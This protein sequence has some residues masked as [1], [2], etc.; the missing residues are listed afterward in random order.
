MDPSQTPLM[1]PLKRLSPYGIAVVLTLAAFLVR[2]AILPHIGSS[3]PFITFFLA[4]LL[5]TLNG[6]ARPGLFCVALS[7]VASLYFLPPVGSLVIYNTSDWMS[8]AL[9]IVVATSLVLLTESLRTARDRA[10]ANAEDAR[11]RQAEVEALQNEVEVRLRE[12]TRQAQ[13]L[14]TLLDNIPTGITIADA[15]DMRIRKISRYGEQ[16]SGFDGAH[17]E[18]RQSSE[19][20]S[21]VFHA[22]GVT[23]AQEEELPLTRATRYGERVQGEEW[24]LVHPQTGEKMRLYCNAAPVQDEEGNILCGILVW[25][26]ISPLKAAQEEIEQLNERLHRSVYESSHRIKNQLQI[27][28][29]TA[30]LILMDETEVV[31]AEEVRRLLAQIRAIAATHDLLTQDARADATADRIS[32]KALMERVLHA[33]QQTTDCHTVRYALADAPLPVKAATSPALLT[34]EAVSDGIKHGGGLIEVTL[35]IQDQQMRLEICDNGPGFPPDFDA[36]RAAN[37]GLEL[38]LTL[39]QM[40]LRGTVQFSNRPE[41][42]GKVAIQCPLPA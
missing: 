22:D 41:G 11:Q 26:D 19:I 36:V 24:V 33:L 34:N 4:V 39:T 9:F 3:T 21:T 1:T 15:P 17:I 12:T 37:T 16:I 10:I 38:L 2:L 14:E 23:P 18:N 25:S 35:E 7:A 13:L 8:I 32:L 27:L 30:D 40:D 31:S 29:A 6:G 5:T 20:P 42:G 28:A